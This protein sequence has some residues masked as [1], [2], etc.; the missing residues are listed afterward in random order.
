MSISTDPYS[1][2]NLVVEAYW[3]C[4]GIENDCEI[5]GKEK[6]SRI[7]GFEW[8]LASP[9]DTHTGHASGRRMHRPVLIR[10]IMDKTTPLIMDAIATN[11]KLNKSEIIVCQVFG[12]DPKKQDKFKV[13][14]E[15]V[16]FI[17]CATIGGE[18]GATV[19]DHLKMVF[20]RI[21]YEDIPSK[22]IAVDDW[23]EI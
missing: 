10:K 16:R 9:V 5:K 3:K 21:T 14:L 4:D 6:Y 13:S 1:G 8:G 7:I 17:E 2:G 18:D 23:R 12:K 11:K 22:K 20:D 19:V 15:G